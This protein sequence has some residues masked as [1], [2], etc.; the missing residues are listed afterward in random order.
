M[1]KPLMLTLSLSVSLS[2]CSPQ[3]TEPLAQADTKTAAVIDHHTSA[4]ALDW[5]GTYKGIL[6]CADCEGIETVLK[7]NTDNSYQLSTT[8]VGKD[9]TAF[10]QLGQFKWDSSGSVVQLLE[11]KDG[12]AYYKVI[13]NQLI[14]LDMSGQIISGNL[15]EKYKLNKQAAVTEYKLT[16]VRW[17]L[18]ELMGQ[19][20]TAT[21]PDQ[22]PYLEFG[23]DNR[24]SGFSGCNQ[25]T[26]AYEAKGLSLSFK[27][28]ATT[29]KACLNASVEEQ[30]LQTIQGV[31]NYTV[32]ESGLALYKARTAAL[33]RFSAVTPSL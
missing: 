13:E 1:F 22:T 28:M 6:P 11:Q 27:P 18:S 12:P 33:V 16:G 17:K 14:Q 25:F 10:Q 2:A 29:Q 4:N 5:A 7:L 30:F 9:A 26:G 3:P 21:E 24:V 8:Y 23:E 31:D 15:A 32:N 19:A 20:I